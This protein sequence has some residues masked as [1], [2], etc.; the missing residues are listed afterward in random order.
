MASCERKGDEG[1]AQKRR[2]KPYLGHLNA[3][4]PVLR[5]EKGGDVVVDQAVSLVREKGRGEEEKRS[6][7]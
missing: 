7:V 5:G 1:K 4:G 6:R 2:R 3:L